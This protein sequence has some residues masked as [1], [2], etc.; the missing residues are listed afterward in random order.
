MQTKTN[1]LSCFVNRF[2]LFHGVRLF[3]LFQLN[4]TNRMR[5]PGIKHPISLRKNTSDIPTFQQIFLDREYNTFLGDKVNNIVDAGANIGLFTALIKNR[6]PEARVISIEPDSS[7]YKMMQRNCS[8]YEC[9]AFERKGLWSKDCYLKVSSTD[10]GSYWGLTT[11]ECE[12]E[13]ANVVAISVD[14]IM[15]SYRLETID[16]FKIDIETAE[17]KLFSENYENWLPKCKT[18]VI[19]FHDRMEPDTS[20]PFF[21][22][23][24]KCMKSYSLR[25]KGENIIIVNNDLQ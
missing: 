15:K 5:I 3:A 9:L 25:C 20:R 16:L 13:N 4:L 17:K 21:V 11:K 7:N 2:G 22:A 12:V 1:K 14:S 8:E 18:I 6:Y 10:D 19:E 23:I 24:N